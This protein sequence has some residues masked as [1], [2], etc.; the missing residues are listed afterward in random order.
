MDI[1]E[2]ALVAPRRF[3]K[4]LLVLPP[5]AEDWVRVRYLFCGVCGSDLS[6]F[7]NRRPTKLPRSMG[8]EFLARV[9]AVGASVAEFAIGDIVTSDLNFRCGV[10][11]QCRDGR[12][13]LCE[14]G[15][16]GHFTNRAFSDYADLHQSYLYK[17][18]G[19]AA[20]YQF[21]LAEPLSC[22]LHGLD[23]L[24]LDEASDT[25][26]VGGGSLGFCAA[27]VLESSSRLG[28]FD[29]VEE[30]AERRARLTKTLKR[31]RCVEAATKQYESVIDLSGS[32][33]GLALALDHVRDGG[34]LCS[35]SHLDGQGD[36]DF[37]PRRLQR[38]DI[39]FKISYLNGTQMR[40]AIQL[41]DRNWSPKWA[42]CIAL[43]SLANVQGVFSARATAPANKDII[44]I[45]SV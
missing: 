16:E 41:I 27:F 25:L 18:P 43:H 4:R 11:A 7:D 45:D 22:V 15:Q 42:D 5:L 20:D 1:A 35:L 26:V 17:T 6:H 9:E 2:F 3:E 32:P 39:T 10:C 13:H 19:G 24:Q 14:R 31:G 34:R 38:R 33:S 21:S 36:G 23:W 8:H 28:S 29:L 40:E 30:N 37:V 44:V 12:S